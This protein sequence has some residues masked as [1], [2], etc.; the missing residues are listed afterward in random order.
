MEYGTETSLF[1][2]FEF[3]VLSHQAAT[4]KGEDDEDSKGTAINKQLK[5]K[6]R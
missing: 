4:M 2:H 5:A 6:V 1:A 3:P